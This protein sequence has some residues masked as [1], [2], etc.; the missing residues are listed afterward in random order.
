MLQRPVRKHGSTDNRIQRNSPKRTGVQADSAIVSHDKELALWNRCR[1][2]VRHHIAMNV[3]LF[4]SVTVDEHFAVPGFDSLTREPDHSLDVGVPRSDA[5]RPEDDD[6]PATRLVE[7][8]RQLINHDKVIGKDSR[9]HR[10]HLNPVGQYNP[11]PKTIGRTEG[12]GYDDNPVKNLAQN[13]VQGSGFS[14]LLDIAG[15]SDPFS[16]VVQLGT[17]H[18]SVTHNFELRNHGRI[19]GENLFD[20][21]AG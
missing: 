21:N 11:V 18:V 19:E 16:Q 12:N 9:L 7:V 5:R 2:E 1:T 10:G 8:I 14:L 20:P 6:I 4:N 17:M 13:S 15:C 3:W